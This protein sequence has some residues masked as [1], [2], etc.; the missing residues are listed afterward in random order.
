MARLEFEAKRLLPRTPFSDGALVWLRGNLP[1]GR[2]SI[3]AI[4]TPRLDTPILYYV[5]ISIYPI[6]LL[7]DSR[8]LTF[9]QIS[10]LD[11]L[12]LSPSLPLLASKP[13]ARVLLPVASG[14]A[15]AT[16]S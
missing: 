4:G 14:I 2:L 3:K 1:P 13:P 8:L 6:L 10:R 5:F 12:H 11:K 15:G 16:R 7:S 9:M